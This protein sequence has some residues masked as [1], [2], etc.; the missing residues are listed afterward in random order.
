MALAYLSAID[1]REST[2]ELG[3]ML[4]LFRVTRA[5]NKYEETLCMY[6][7]Y[8]LALDKQLIQS[9]ISKVFGFIITKNKIQEKLDKDFPEHEIKLN[10]N[11]IQVLI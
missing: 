9:C 4:N 3:C 8:I 7:L 6:V 10:H 2:R 11:I 1:F 5:S